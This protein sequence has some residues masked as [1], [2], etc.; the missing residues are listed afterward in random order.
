MKDFQQQVLDKGFV[1]LVDWMGTDAEICEAARVSYL[2][3]AGVKPSEEDDNNLIRYLLRHRH[4]SPFEMAEIKFHLKMPIF[5]ARQW[6]RHRMSSTNEVSGRY[7]ELPFECFELGPDEWRKQ[8]KS[9]KQGS[10]EDVVSGEGEIEDLMYMQGQIHQEA[11]ETYQGYLETGV[12]KELA[13]KDLP[14]SIYT[15]FYWKID[16]HNLLHFLGLRMDSHAQQEIREYANVIGDIVKQL[17]PQTWQAF[18][19]YR[20][21]AITLSAIDIQVLRA[22]ITSCANGA[23]PELTP[24]MLNVILPIQWLK[25][26]C[27]EAAEVIS[28][29][30]RI[31]GEA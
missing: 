5:V 31:M 29:L 23:S 20:F 25:P 19:D 12:A 2:N 15:E 13:R 17:F 4:T 8:S 6:V 1:R 3:H 27:R 11:E 21:N 30:E 22:Y 9:N 14:L 26:K 28:K 16:L 24:E 10:S 7:R 18:L